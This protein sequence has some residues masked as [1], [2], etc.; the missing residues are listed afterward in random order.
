M[1]QIYLDLVEDLQELLDEFYLLAEKIAP[2]FL[3]Y[4]N[5]IGIKY[6]NTYYQM[7]YWLEYIK[8][9]IKYDD[10]NIEDYNHLLNGLKNVKDSWVTVNI[11]L[12]A[13]F[14][15]GFY[16][17]DQWCFEKKLYKLIQKFE[18][19]IERFEKYKIQQD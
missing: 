10:I 18:I 7:K 19:L 11:F 13:A 3:F 1:K 17:P 4:L 12:V 14:N 16:H 5:D 15:N 9:H 2:I 6:V 8:D